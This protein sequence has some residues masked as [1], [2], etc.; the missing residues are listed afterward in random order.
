MESK[1]RKFSTSH[2]HPKAFDLPTVT[3]AKETKAL[4]RCIGK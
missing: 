1:N 2:M 4:V 3:V